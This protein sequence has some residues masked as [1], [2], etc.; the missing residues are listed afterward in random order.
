K[1]GEDTLLEIVNKRSSLPVRKHSPLMQYSIKEI[2][3]MPHC[4]FQ[5]LI[6]WVENIYI[7]LNRLTAQPTNKIE[8]SLSNFPDSQCPHVGNKGKNIQ[9][10]KLSEAFEPLGSSNEYSYQHTLKGET[11]YVIPTNFLP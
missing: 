11:I 1:G 3:N 6:N 9:Y 7:I 10:L 2:L 8:Y 5:R 4:E